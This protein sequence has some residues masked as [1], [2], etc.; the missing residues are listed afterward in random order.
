V[1]KKSRGEESDTTVSTA[2]DASRTVEVKAVVTFALFESVGFKVVAVTG[3][4]TLR[5]IVFSFGIVRG[6]LRMGSEAWLR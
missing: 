4:A 2:R 1:A 3:V 5:D 6:L